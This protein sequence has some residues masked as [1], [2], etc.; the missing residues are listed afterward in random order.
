MAKINSGMPSTN[1]NN[2]TRSLYTLL[3]VL[4]DQIVALNPVAFAT[5]IALTAADGDIVLG[6]TGAVSNLVITLPVAADS[7]GA[8]ITV[9]KVDSPAKS[10]V[11]T[12][13]DVAETIDGATTYSLATQ[14]EAVTLYCDGFVWHA[15]AYIA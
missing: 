2:N 1:T 7:L 9:K 10:V 4:T 3:Q 12:P 8:Y 5:D 15:V 13:D 14:Y 11:V 6:T